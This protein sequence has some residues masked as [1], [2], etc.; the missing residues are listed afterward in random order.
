MKNSGDYKLVDYKI[1]QGRPSEVEDRVSHLINNDVG[2]DLNGE[3]FMVTI[4]EKNIVAQSMVKYV[5]P[6]KMC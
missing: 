4:G 5:K 3:P 2:W 1:I 6:V